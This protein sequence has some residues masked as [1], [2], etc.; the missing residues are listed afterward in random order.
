MDESWRMR[1]G[2][3][4]APPPPPTTT[5]TRHIPNYPPRRSTESHRRNP[6]SDD[7]LNPDDFSDVFGGPPRTIL[8]RQYSTGLPIRSS[9]S[10][11][12]EEVFRPPETAAAE[13]IGRSLPEFRI[14]GQKSRGE[15]NNNG[16][17]SDIFGWE[18][19]RVVRSRSRSKASSSSVL[20]SE[21]LSPL[22]PAVSGDGYDDVS[23]FASKLRPINVRSGWFS[24]RM[25]HE[26]N[27]RQQNMMPP[28]SGNQSSYNN[29]NHCPFGLNRRNSS[30]ETISLEPMSNGSFRVSGD[31]MEVNSPSS[32]VSSVCHSSGQ[33]REM[34]DEIPGEDSM[35]EE[36]DEAMSSYVI[37]INSDYY[38]EGTCESNGV[39]EAIAWAKE[40]FQTPYREESKCVMQECG[41]HKSAQGSSEF[42]LL[43]KICDTDIDYALL[44][45]F[46]AEMLN[47]H[48]VSEG[49]TD[50][51][52]SLDQKWAAEEETQQFEYTV[53][54]EMQIL[55]EKMKLWS[56]G[57][58]ADIRSLLSSLHHILWPNSGWSAV[59]LTNI[60][61][62]AQV[63]KA[64]QKARFCLHP[65]KLQQR[66]ATIPQ[67]Y[68][69]KKVF[70]V[71]QDA[72]S[73][74]ISQDVL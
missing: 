13:R 74:L 34:E 71:L 46:Y 20:S 49:H 42:R 2:M 38:R 56:T 23:V 59:H 8:S 22:R 50:S 18:N 53:H 37:E 17:Y 70:C 39:D 10:F 60:T 28:F 14:P 32:A 27:Q 68:I 33:K 12:Y 51:F 65:D 41:T 40:K 11:S 15:H 43:S 48:Q 24:T 73:A 5:T 47:G 64:Y 29:E 30:P 3:P 58:E 69:A 7:P 25:G 44:G 52:G 62:I 63:K 54:T 67:K 66:G 1:M 26:D 19:E 72:W 45:G 31:D 55:D 9:S 16:F 6:L 57:K 21:E 61:E 36:E 35:D 4:T